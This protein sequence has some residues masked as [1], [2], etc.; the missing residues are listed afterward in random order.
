MVSGEWLANRLDDF[1]VHAPVATPFGI[2]KSIFSPAKR[3]EAKREELL[4]LCGL[5][6]EASLCVIVSR[7]HPEKRLG[8]VLDAFLKLQETR[9][10]GLVVFGTGFMS[11][12]LQ[13]R[14]HE[15]QGVHIAGFTKDREELAQVYASS[16]VM[17][18]GSAAETFGLG[19]AE[20]YLLGLADC[21]TLGRWC[22]RFGWEWLWTSVRTGRCRWLRS[23]CRGGLRR[24]A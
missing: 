21:C 14:F 6:P 11:E 16:D 22:G 3:S 15:A 17:L 13:R 23:S 8:V 2:D 24:G 10:A 5:G 7:F 19:V 1:G 4:K 12:K 20:G 18:H 9:P